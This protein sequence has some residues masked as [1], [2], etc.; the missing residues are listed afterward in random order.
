M[1]V[2][3]IWNWVFLKIAI[4]LPELPGKYMSSVQVALPCWHWSSWFERL[5]VNCFGDS[6]PVEKR[7]DGVEHSCRHKEL[8][9]WFGYKWPSSTFRDKRP[10]ITQDSHSP[11]FGSLLCGLFFSWL[12]ISVFLWANSLH[13]NSSNWVDKVLINVMRGQWVGVISQCCMTGNSDR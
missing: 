8:G 10:H 12:A 5:S 3:L 2:S 7:S 9:I 6:F 4:S 11:K 13:M 1:K